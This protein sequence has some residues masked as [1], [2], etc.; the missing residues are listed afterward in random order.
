MIVESALT[1]RKTPAELYALWRDLA[2]AQDVLTHV[3]RVTSEGGGH[4]H[5]TLARSTGP[6]V[7]WD[8]E[9]TEEAENAALA[10]RS[11]PGGP[12]AAEGRVSFVPILDG[13]A[14]EV[15]LVLSYVPIEAA[16]REAI[17]A[18]FGADAP[19]QVDR[20]MQRLKE[21]VESGRLPAKDLVQQT[22]ED[23]FPASDPPAW[24]GGREGR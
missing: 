2:V 24:A 9:V 23:S 20:D 12:L 22:S 8:T 15:R 11:C 5:W 6:V 13:A 16:A 21:H 18:A 3:E 7:E 4:S 17:T 10:W 19:R 14:T 1:I